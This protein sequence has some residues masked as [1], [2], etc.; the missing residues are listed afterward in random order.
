MNELISL[1]NMVTV[2]QTTLDN[3]GAYI[4]IK[5]LEGKY[6]FVNRLVKELFD[7]PLEEI[8]GFDDSK[9][10]SL[11]I[12]DDLRVNDRLVMDQGQTIEKEEKNHV[13][14]TGEIKYYWTVKKPRRDENGKI[15]GMYGISTD[16][17][18]T[19]KLENE[20]NQKNAEL[21][22]Y[23]EIIHS[24][25]NTAKNIQKNLLPK[26]LDLEAGLDISVRYHPLSEVG[27]D[28]YDVHRLRND[29]IRI[30]LADATGHGIQAALMTMSIH[31]EY[32]SIKD[33]ILPPGRILTI[34]NTRY[35]RRYSHLNSFFSCLILDI[36]LK[37]GIISYSSAGHPDQILY[38]SERQI[39]LKSTGKIIGVLENV[40]YGTREENFGNSDRLCLFS[41]GI[42]EMI[43]P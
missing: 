10:F 12:S 22:R 27:G 29:T 1:K 43:N 24:D 40:E 18:Q 35:F 26:N 4:Y 8:I 13:I 19:K 28:I 38:N 31:S 41:D 33:Y 17:T 23:L 14:K 7:A 11:E 32:L 25:L 6:I 2:L 39:R 34:L 36:D 3:I 9:F 16:I 5:D 30:F 37:E 20:V 15:T 21:L 42:Y